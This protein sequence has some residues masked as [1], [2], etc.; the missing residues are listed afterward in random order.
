MDVA[1]L[2]LLGAAGGALRGVLDVYIRFLDWHRDRRV[3]LRLPT[4]QEGGPPGFRSYFDPVGDPVA[5][6]VHSAMGAGAAVLLGTTGQ[7]SGAY[8]AVVV[9]MS[10]PVI[11]TQLGRAQT[12]G[13]AL[14]TVAPAEAGAQQGPTEV[15][16]Q[17]S[18]SGQ[19]TEHAPA[20]PA[21][22]AGGSPLHSAQLAPPVAVRPPGPHLV[23]PVSLDGEGPQ[24]DVRAGGRPVEPG[25]AL[26][27]GRPLDPAS[28][29]NRGVGSRDAPPMAQGPTGAE[30]GTG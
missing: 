22:P 14:A 17:P 28:G 2:A 26:P 24:A 23:Q 8:A 13:E 1:T 29:S 10:A 3:H 19:P 21:D 6:V 30:E 15:A 20:Q 11:L 16:P 18:A 4:G 9:G 27:N 12:V 7:I 25:Q 5:A